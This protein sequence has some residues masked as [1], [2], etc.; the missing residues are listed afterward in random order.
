MKPPRG[1]PGR[2]GSIAVLAAVW[3]LSACG[4]GAVSGGGS[5]PPRVQPP[6]AG[7][8]PPGDDTSGEGVAT[9]DPAQ[10]TGRYRGSLESDPN[11]LPYRRVPVV[12]VSSDASHCPAERRAR[13]ARTA[14][15]KGV[16]CLRLVASADKWTRV[17]IAPGGGGRHN[18]C[19]ESIGNRPES[20]ALAIPGED[21]PRDDVSL[22][23][24]ELPGGRALVFDNAA[25]WG[26]TD[27]DDIPLDCSR[28]EPV[29]V[30]R[31]APGDVL[32]VRV[33]RDGAR[34][35]R[36]GPAGGGGMPR[37]SAG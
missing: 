30:W 31:A 21:A 9:G 3:A 32:P 34:P 6:T 24:S 11:F 27:R 19:V 10:A 7:P 20:A 33:R 8:S 15:G 26:P 12:V 16:Q 35:L 23:L 2:G 22:S 18:V 37:R 14:L 4:R 13:F 25:R 36:G 17:V 29:P 5:H 1:R 28:A